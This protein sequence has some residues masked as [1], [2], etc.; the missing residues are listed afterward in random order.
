MWSVE[1]ANRTPVC[2][3]LLC[4]VHHRLRARCFCQILVHGDASEGCGRLRYALESRYTD[5][6]IRIIAPRNLQTVELQFRAQKVAKTVGALAAQPPSDGA[7]LSGLIVRKNFVDYTLMREEELS[8]FTALA[9]TTVEQSIKVPFH[10]TFACMKYFVGQMYELDDDDEEEDA[11]KKSGDLTM[12]SES[13]KQE[14]IT[15]SESAKES[16]NQSED[17]HMADASPASLAADAAVAAAPSI[18]VHSS[19]HLSYHVQPS[20][21]VL[22]RWKSNPVND[23]LSDSLIAILTNIQSNPGMA[24]VIGSAGECR[25]ANVTGHTHK[26]AATATTDAHEH[27]APAVA[28]A[29]SSSDAATFEPVSK[30]AAPSASAPSFRW[31]LEQHYGSDIV[32]DPLNH[33]YAFTLNTIPC[34]VHMRTLEVECRDA[35]LRKRISMMI[36]RAHAACQ[37]ITRKNTTTIEEIDEK[38]EKENQKNNNAAATNGTIVTASNPSQPAATLM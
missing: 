18:T 32:F 22:V 33:T 27:T 13:T 10:Q 16:K 38:E 4:V 36:R 5:G 11:E 8:H 1:H 7:M 9:S 20:P 26:H 19:V 6:S 28:A 35:E 24:K 14:G 12:K 25:N 2:S 23:M 37:P 34:V 3:I 17:T 15:K 21:H 31:F 30:P 29:S